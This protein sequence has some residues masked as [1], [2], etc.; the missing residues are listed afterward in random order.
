MHTPRADF[1]LLY[2]PRPPDL[3]RLRIPMRKWQNS[4]I[5]Q[6]AWELQ[7]Y[8]LFWGEEV[9]AVVGYGRHNLVKLWQKSPWFSQSESLLHPARGVEAVVSKNIVRFG[10]HMLKKSWQYW[11]SGHSALFLHLGTLIWGEVV[12]AGTWGLSTHPKRAWQDWLLL[13]SLSL[14]QGIVGFF[15]TFSFIL[16]FSW[17]IT[18]QTFRIVWHTS[19]FWQSL[20]SRHCKVF[21]LIEPSSVISLL[22]RSKGSPL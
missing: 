7:A 12:T 14:L 3:S 10:R 8:A 1:K 13:Q 18:K 22:A 2:G 16:L 17:G 19:P 11:P 20:S 4:V 15:S 6:S 21:F 5:L 9:M